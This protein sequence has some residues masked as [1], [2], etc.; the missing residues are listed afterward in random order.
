MSMNDGCI[1][2]LISRTWGWVTYAYATCNIDRRFILR[3][4][5]FSIRPEAVVQEA[6]NGARVVVGQVRISMLNPSD[7]VE[8]LG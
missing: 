1:K 2:Y 7:S 3:D 4:V 5:H 6:A 8:S